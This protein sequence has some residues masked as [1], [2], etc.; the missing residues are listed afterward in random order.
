MLPVYCTYLLTIGHQALNCDTVSW[1]K[2]PQTTIQL[3]LWTAAADVEYCLSFVTST[4]S[5]DDVAA[6]LLGC[7]CSCRPVIF[8]CSVATAAE[9][10]RC[11][12]YGRRWWRR[13]RRWCKLIRW[14]L[15]TFRCAMKLC[16]HFLQTLAVNERNLMSTFWLSYYR[17]GQR[18]LGKLRVKKAPDISQ[19]GVTTPLRFD[20][21]FTTTSVDGL[22]WRTT[23]VSRHQVKVS[24]S[25]FYWSKRRWGDS[26]I[27]QNL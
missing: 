27:S 11:R 13:R 14:Q 26:G 15:M 5:D 10:G 4:L 25:G 9:W 24:H 8:G 22:F 19:G 16:R 6:Y 21:I 20:G 7:V 18:K 17:V 1:V 3:G 12:C 2:L 23:W